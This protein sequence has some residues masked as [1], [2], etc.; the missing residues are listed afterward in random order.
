MKWLV[1]HPGAESSVSD[2]YAGVTAGLKAEGVEYAE[3]RLDGRIDRANAWLHYL[4]RRAKK[5]EPAKVWP[6]PTPADVL[7]HAS[8]GIVERALMRNCDVI[9]VITAMYVQPDLLTLARRA[10]LK[11]YLLCTES[12]YELVHERRLAALCNAVWTNERTAVAPLRES[13]EQVAYL[14]HAWI[15]GVHD[16]PQAS[17]AG[18]A[19]HDVVFVGTF[20]EE[21]VTLLESVDW[22]GI[23]LGLYG[24]THLIKQTSPIQQF[25]RGGITANGV[26]A[27]LYRRATLG[28]NLY[29]QTPIG[30]QVAESL[31]PRAYELAAAGVC[32]VS[33]MRA[34]VA[35]VF[36]AS[37]PMFKDGAELGVLVRQ[38]LDDEGARA[39]LAQAAR[40]AVTAQTWPSRIQRMRRDLIGWQAPVSRFQRAG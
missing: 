1:V 11:V 6:K 35:E 5:A 40:E 25:I 21:R 2:V 22:T 28:L 15:P 18:L 19:A 29:R 37:V 12:P 14:P 17:D 36:P 3:F 34:E 20:F 9:L 27:G 10:G 23:D 31:N 16:A 32:Q 13:C 8:M 7:L 26:A 4:Y 38:L 33:E 24:N 30:C 39:R